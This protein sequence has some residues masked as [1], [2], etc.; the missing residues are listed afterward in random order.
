MQSSKLWRPPGTSLSIVAVVCRVV[1][2]RFSTSRPSNCPSRQLDLPREMFRPSAR[3]RNG[4]NKAVT[5][6]VRRL[7]LLR[8]EAQARLELRDAKSCI[9]LSPEDKIPGR[10]DDYG[11]LF[12]CPQENKT[13]R[14]EHLVC[15]E[16]GNVVDLV[17]KSLS[18]PPSYVEELIHFGAVYY[19]L[20][21]PPP[22]KG[23]LSAAQMELYKKASALSQNK[24]RP[25]LKGKTLVEAQKAF[26][27]TSIYEGI[28]AGTYLRVHV[29][30]KRFP[31]CYEVDWR[32]RVIAQTEAYLVLDK[33]AGV[34][35]GGAVDNIVECCSVFTARSLGL[36]NTLRLTHQLDNCTEGCVV[37]A[38]SKEFSSEFHALLR[39]REVQKYYLALA[40]AP[41]PLG[42]ITHFMQPSPRHPRIVSSAPYPGWAR[43][44]LEVLECKEVLWPATEA[45]AKYRIKDSG[46]ETKKFAYECK[47]EILTGRTHQIRAQFAALGAPLIGDSMYMPPVVSRLKSPELQPCYLRSAKPKDTVSDENGLDIDEVGLEKWIS[48][49][50][51]EPECAIGLQ[52][53]QISWDDGASHFKAGEPWWNQCV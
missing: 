12:P 26:R 1:K 42:R 8:R 21:C 39:K 50:G 13:P 47:V 44:E 37:L 15:L 28:E 19:A 24:K 30:I 17:S 2:S 38:K 32:S 36:S 27:I 31:R 23:S 3:R 52:A 53:L 18:L 25:S 34:P 41:V 22:P 10:F 7:G 9:V 20:V 51:G 33:P 4:L 49:H 6:H 5:V 14:I 40:A 46:W 29:H 11:S 43:C 45:E 16:D 48:L 35:V